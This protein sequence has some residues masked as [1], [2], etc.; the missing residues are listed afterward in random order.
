MCTG[1]AS[2]TEWVQFPVLLPIGSVTLDMGINLLSCH[3]LP[4]KIGMIY[5]G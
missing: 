4:C 2:E 5:H 1:L 3:F